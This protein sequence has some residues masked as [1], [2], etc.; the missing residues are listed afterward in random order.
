[1]ELGG[2]P[3]WVARPD[4]SVYWRDDF[5]VLD[6]ETTTILKGSPLVAENRIIL[7]C[8][9]EGLSPVVESCFGTE[10]EQ[11]RL[12]EACERASFI[13][14]HNAKFELGWLKRCGLDLR[15]VI[16]YDTMIGEY[17]LAGNTLMMRQLSLEMS[18]ERRGFPGKG[19]TIAKM[20]KAQI[21]TADMPESWLLKYCDRDVTACKEMFRAQL[22]DLRAKGLEAINYQ[23]NLVTPALADIEFEGMQLDEGK[24]NELTEEMEDEYA[25]STA[26]LQEFCEGASPS[27]PKQLREFIFG[28]LKFKVPNDHRGKPML[29]RTGDPS[30]AADVL[31][32]LKPANDRQRA[33][34]DLHTKWALMHSDVT[35]YLRKFGECCTEIGGLLRASFNQCNTRTHRLSSSGLQWKVQF[36]N[37]NRRFK[38]LFKA[39]KDDWL[40][41]EADGAQLEFRVATHLGRDRAALADIL[42][43]E[44]IHAYTASIIGVSRQDA[45]AHTFK[46]L[47]GGKSGTKRERK[48]YEAFARKYNQITATQDSWC[49][50]VADDKELTTEWGMKYY[51]PL[52]TRN[53]KSG[54]IS[55]TTS[56][57]NYPVQAFATAEIIPIAI[58]CA[59]HRMA[60]FKSFLVNTVHD[61]I[62]AELH[63]DEIA[64]WHEVAQVCL[65]EDTYTLINALYGVELTVPLG[66]GVMVGERWADKGSKMGERIYTAR[67][68]LWIDA[69]REA[70]MI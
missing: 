37:L 46:P 2:L 50:T 19:D 55:F 60:N 13:V 35:K 28:N 59:W 30:V 11:S 33:F 24:V 54:Y 23:R 9:S 42:S 34:L 51:W 7:A 31:A 3:A 22:V 39:R 6:F 49:E 8:W 14:A 41:G 12:V 17:V 48:Y 62:I 66:A 47:Y 70:K 32:R 36:Q 43:G 64:L 67:E 52:S 57:Y 20:F 38:P 56:I 63:P 45:K 10:Y 61:S 15:K 21:D 40:I 69:A 44:D 26:D 53:E 27:S 65:I 18:L 16:T 58:V 29:T 68:E 25:R 5:V 4:P 1:M